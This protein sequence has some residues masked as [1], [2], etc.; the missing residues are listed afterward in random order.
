[1][2]SVLDI[3]RIGIGP[4]S[5]HTVGPIRIAKRFGESLRRKERLPKIA[6]VVVELQGSLALTGKG[7][8][9]PKAVILGLL[10]LEP[11]TLNPETADADVARVYI[12]KSLKLLGE[13]PISFDPEAD[14]IFD[15]ETPPKLHPNGMKLSAFDG[16]G[17]LLRTQTYYSTG[18]GFIASKRQMEMPVQDDLIEVGPNV[19]YPLAR[20]LN[21][22]T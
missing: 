7:H 17:S 5:S 15:F 12:D 13:Q 8:A 21:C 14:L 11:E 16:A 4:S 10:G 18:G 1:M 3:F 2:L 22:W 6:R 20:R 9:T 19:P